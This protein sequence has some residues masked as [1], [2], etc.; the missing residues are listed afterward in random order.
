MSAA[1]HVGEFEQLVLLAVLRQPSQATAL[2]VLAELE[3]RA[4]RRVT[5]GTLYKTLDRLESKGLIDWAVEE[6]G[7]E[8]GGHPRRLF[9]VTAA[10]MAVLRTT[11]TTL[12]RMWDGLESVLEGRN[13]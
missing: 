1:L 2:D 13:G 9:R 4:G 8:R 11:R 6:A 5:R 12:A 3:R 10:G 7:P